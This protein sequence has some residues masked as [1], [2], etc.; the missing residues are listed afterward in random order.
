MKFGLKEE[1]IENMQNVFSSFPEVEQVVI[2]GSRAKGNYKA[3]S[4]LDITVKGNDLN[5]S[6]LNNIVLK[7]DDLMLPYIIDISLYNQIN[8]PDLIDHIDRVGIIFYQ[9]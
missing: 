8:N 6:K 4:D 7:L 9:R 3:G 2:Y 1:V 5:L